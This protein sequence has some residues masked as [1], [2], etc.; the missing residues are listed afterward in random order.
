MPPPNRRP[1]FV[2]PRELAPI[3]RA[4]A[5]EWTE[6]SIE[7]VRNFDNLVYRIAAE[8]VLYLRI[9]RAAHRSQDQVRSELAV[10]QHAG[11]S[12]LRVARPLLSRSGQLIHCVGS[13][14]HELIACAFREA[15]GVAYEDWKDRNSPAFFLAVGESMGRLHAS[16]SAFVKP[17]GFQRF[18]W[19]EDRWSR[20]AE[21]VPT[22]E[23]RAWELF[24]ELESW[25]RGLAVSEPGFGLIH[26]DFTILNFRISER[27]TCLFDFDSCCEH[28]RA[29]EIATFLHFFGV[30]DQET[31]RKAYD[32]AL[33]GYARACCLQTE[34][35]QQIPKFAHMRLLYS[36]LVFA[37]QWGFKNLTAEQAAYFEHRRRAFAEES[38][39]LNAV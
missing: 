13:G 12:G 31:R 8:P 7:F 3:A 18:P 10:V 29:Y 2:E 30:H 24:K 23:T 19:K 9:T 32:N 11:D 20:F 34:V 35:V 4:L 25:T 16:L 15:E 33:E 28:W 21:H 39:W 38:V 14:D 36:F 5:S 27:G 17:T 1:E 6:S 26:G 22:S 37:E